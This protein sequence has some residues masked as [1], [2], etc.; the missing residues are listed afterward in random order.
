MN[1]LKKGIMI[2]GQKFILLSITVYFMAVLLYLLC[3][4][5]FIYLEAFLILLGGLQTLFEKDE[6][7]GIFF[8]ISSFAHKYF[9]RR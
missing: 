8:G 6:R 7:Y 3:E 4:L 1:C 2:P 9:V 5:K